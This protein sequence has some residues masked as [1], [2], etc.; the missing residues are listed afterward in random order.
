VTAVLSDDQL[1]Q[2]RLAC[3][4]YTV[5]MTV[6]LFD[7]HSKTFK[8]HAMKALATGVLLEYQGQHVLVTASHVLDSAAV[9]NQGLYVL[10]DQTG[11]IDLGE[12]SFVRT[13]SSGDRLADDDLDLAVLFLEPAIAQRLRITGGFEFTTLLPV[14]SEGPH[15]SCLHFIHGFPV[16]LTKPKGSQHIERVSLAIFLSQPSEPNGSWDSTFPDSHFDLQY[17]VHYVA[18]L[19]GSAAVLKLPPPHGF[20]GCGVW[21]VGLHPG[22]AETPPIALIGIVHRFNGATGV[23]RATRLDVLLELIF[24]SGLHSA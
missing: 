24:N 15:L 20:S 17:A 5:K 2:L 1:E 6:Q 11:F 12:F 7:R 21:R 16:G 3:C 23:L 9:Q 4:N 14:E 13:S 18:A 22:L 8:R 19:D 10:H